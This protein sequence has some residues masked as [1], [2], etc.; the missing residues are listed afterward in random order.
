MKKQTAVFCASLLL[1]IH[2]FA[3]T[4]PAMGLLCAAYDIDFKFD[5]IID[6]FTGDLFENSFALRISSIPIPSKVKQYSN[7]RDNITMVISNGPADGNSDV[8]YIIDLNK[9]YH[10]TYSGHATK[11]FANPPGTRD[12][13]ND[14][15]MSLDCQS[16]KP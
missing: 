12:E 9:S 8:G 1:S 15:Y 16:T 11:Y 14:T 4:P 2:A 3:G 6:Q 13:Q 10:D 7:Y 5:M